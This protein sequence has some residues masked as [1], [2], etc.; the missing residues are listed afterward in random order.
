MLDGKYASDAGIPEQF[1]QLISGFYALDHL[2]FE[3]GPQTTPVF[4]QKL[5]FIAGSHSVFFVSGCSA[6]LHGQDLG[7]VATED[8]LS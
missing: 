6:G 1:C 7:I 2:Q 8:R 4:R 3:V 5:T